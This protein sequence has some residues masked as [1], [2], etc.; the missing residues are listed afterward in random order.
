MSIGKNKNEHGFF[1]SRAH[2]I[3]AKSLPCAKGGVCEADGGIVI[4]S[5]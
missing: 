2:F 4:P 3:F 5:R 1:K